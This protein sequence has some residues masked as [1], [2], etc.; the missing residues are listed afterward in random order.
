MNLNE[1]AEVM[2][3]SRKDIEELLNKQDIIEISLTE[4]K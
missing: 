4:V 2:G 1:L 3:K